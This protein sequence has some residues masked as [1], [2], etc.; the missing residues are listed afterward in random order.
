MLEKFFEEVEAVHQDMNLS[1]S[2]MPRW[3]EYFGP[4]QGFF[5]EC[6]VKIPKDRHDKLQFLPPAPVHTTVKTSD[7]PEH[8]QMLFKERYGKGMSD[9]KTEKLIAS[10]V[11]KENIVLHHSTARI[12]SYI[13]AQITVKRVL[14]FVQDKVLKAW[15][16]KATEGRIRASEAG[17]ELLV[18]FYKLIINATFGQY[19]III[20]IIIIIIITT[21]IIIIII[22]I[23]VTIT[24]TIT[25]IVS[26]MPSF[27][28]S[29]N[30][31]HSYLFVLSVSF[32][33]SHPSIYYLSTSGLSVRPPPQKYSFSKSTL[34]N[35]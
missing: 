9:M 33:S 16:E 13:G 5:I 2:D 10:L 1:S 17:D 12:Y 24:I 25:I 4:N 34:Q 20:V 22:F 32:S 19:I 29:P 6:D 11:D 15:I 23:I 27:C 30:R 35:T 28:V 18:A 21:I 31:L 7:L 3:K 8:I 26:S 14:S